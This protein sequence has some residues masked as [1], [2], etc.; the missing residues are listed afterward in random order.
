MAKAKEL[1]IALYFFPSYSLKLN[2]IERLWKYLKN[3]IA[4]GCFLGFDE[5]MATINR[6]AYVSHGENHDFALDT[7]QKIYYFLKF[8]LKITS[9][10]KTAIK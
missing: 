8:C 2:F 3:K 5:Y 7:K 4:N 6:N 10:D 9:I 1:G